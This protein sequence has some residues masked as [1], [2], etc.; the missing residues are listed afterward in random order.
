[1]AMATDGGRS[2]YVG[3]CS[4]AADTATGF[5]A[6]EDDALG[7]AESAAREQATNLAMRAARESGVELT[8][9][10]RGLFVRDTVEAVARR[11]RD[12]V[13]R[14]RAFHR[15]CAGEGGGVCDL[16]VR[17]SVEQSDW[18]RTRA[19]ALSDLLREERGAAG[20]TPRARLLDWMLQHS[21]DV[22]PWYRDEQG[23]GAETE[24][25]PRS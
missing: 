25:G 3:G 24:G 17:L 11:M 20:E 21:D 23:R 2:L 15:P 10:E 16:F 13:R 12:S 19:E 4:A 5:S 14:D 22:S 6:A 1:M 9:T 7:Q 8:S 18:D